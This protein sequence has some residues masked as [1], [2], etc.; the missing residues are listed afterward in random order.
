[1]PF[2][3]SEKT[4]PIV[5]DD[6]HFPLVVQT[7]TGDWGNRDLE[8]M[9][10]YFD[11]RLRGQWRHSAV[12]NVVP[13]SHSLDAAQRKRIATWQESIRDHIVRNNISTA[14]VLSSGLERGAL[15]ALNWL[16]PPPVPQRACSTML[17]AVDWSIERMQSAGLVITPAVAK[18]RGSLVGR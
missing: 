4:M 1:M 11:K 7:M 17:E 5:I 6:T 16:F 8:E 3:A 10:A 9:I 15:T 2:R 18:Y 12:T 14:I 13:G